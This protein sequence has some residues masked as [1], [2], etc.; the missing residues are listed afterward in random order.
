[1]NVKRVRRLCV[2]RRLELKRRIA[3]K[4]RGICK[5]APVRAEHADHVWAYDFVHDVYRDGRRFK[6]CYERTSERRQGL[7][8]LA[9]RL[10]TATLLRDYRVP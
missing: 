9:A 2:E 6:V 8:E 3:R 1:M 5:V 4:R 10:L 7:H